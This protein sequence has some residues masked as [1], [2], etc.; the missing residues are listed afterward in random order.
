VTLAHILVFGGLALAAG[1]LA[2]GRWRGWVILASSVIAVYILQPATPVRYLD[3]WL[4]TATLATSMSGWALT[5]P[6]GSP[7]TTQSWI[8]AG[9]TL[10]MVLLIGATRYL[11]SLCCLTPSQPPAILRVVI[12]I[13]GLAI[14]L[15]VLARFASSR[16]LALA[17][18]LIGIIILMVTLKTEFLA[19]A[20]SAGLR[21]LSAQSPALAK[22]TD[23]RWLGFSYLAFRI[24]ATLR[25]RQVG[26]LADISLR[27][28][29]CY[30]V[31][32]PALTAGPIDRADRFIKELN[33]PV[34]DRWQATVEGSRRLVLGL[35]RK[36]VL[37]DSLAL[38]ALS[39]QNYDQVRSG[40]WMWVILL[41]YAWRI[42][43]D[44]AGYTD[45]AIG[46]GRWMGIKLP[47]NFDK[48]YFKVNLTTFWN[49]WHITLAQ[50][51][52][53]YFFNPLTRAMRS[54]PKPWPQAAV[55]LV[56]QVG[57]M[58]LIGLWH[59][60]TWN[61]LI[62]GLWHA[63]GLFIHNRWLEMVRRRL[64]G[65][66]LP[67][68]VQRIIAILGWLLT[69]TYVTLGWVWFA[70]PEPQQ[71]LHVFGRLFGWQ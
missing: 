54:A 29:L 10:G 36:F 53:T 34:F 9:V 59:G 23:I 26:R 38:V 64:D 68:G 12:A 50:F 20:A 1:W 71:S 2:N 19:Q 69:F 52:R 51:F 60:I 55:I 4:P 3:F 8:A 63:A 66:V 62:W 16:P 14:I 35:L 21:L 32:F 67:V 65:K 49:S 15:V 40:G 28:Y 44:F 39:L 47:E 24:I 30:V 42:Y 5:R 27:D 31:F 58:S 11:G 33:Q 48:P 45:I 61:F 13:I 6:K 70:L 25:D 57:T 7:V 56:G 43:F 41:A 18:G 37:A 22:A 46:I 17:A